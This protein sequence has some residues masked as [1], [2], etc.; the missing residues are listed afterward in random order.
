MDAFCH[1]EEIPW[2][3]NLKSFLN[4]KLTSNIVNS[5]TSIKITYFYANIVNYI[6]F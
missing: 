1:V 6:D 4:I 3:P 2:Y 5:F